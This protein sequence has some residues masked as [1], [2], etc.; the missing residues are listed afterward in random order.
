MSIKDINQPITDIT[1]LKYLCVYSTPVHRIISCL[2]IITAK[3]KTIARWDQ[4]PSLQPS[5]WGGGEIIECD[6]RKSTFAI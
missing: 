2:P 4:H 5:K 3:I 1:K 6:L